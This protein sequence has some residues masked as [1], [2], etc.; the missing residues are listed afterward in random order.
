ME[1]TNQNK[2]HRKLSKICKLLQTIH[3]EFQPHSKAIKQ[4]ERE[5]RMGM[6]RRTP[7]SFR[8][9]Q[10]QNN[11]STSTLSSKEKRKIQSGNRYFR[12]CNKRSTIPRTRR[13]M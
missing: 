3:L 6:E 11:K 1:D 2:R 4:V 12:I 9:T 13:E 8:R 10:R 5:E 7:T